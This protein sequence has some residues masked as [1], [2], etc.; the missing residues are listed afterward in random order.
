MLD[1]CGL[2]SATRAGISI[3]SV[4]GESC[5]Q[6]ILHNKPNRINANMDLRRIQYV[7]SEGSKMS[8]I[9]VRNINKHYLDTWVCNPTHFCSTLKV[10]ESTPKL[11][12]LQSEWEQR[13]ML[14]H[15]LCFTVA[16]VLG[17]HHLELNAPVMVM[18]VGRKAEGHA[19]SGQHNNWPKNFRVGPQIQKKTEDPWDVDEVYPALVGISWLFEHGYIGY[20]I[21]IYIYVIL[22]VIRITIIISSNNSNGCWAAKF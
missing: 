4:W 22:V 19:P 21:Y 12:L 5:Q 9:F 10:L 3:V 18:F 2:Y 7:S 11:P 16:S 8:G 20:I 14:L 1:E 6:N 13:K 17:S 15:I